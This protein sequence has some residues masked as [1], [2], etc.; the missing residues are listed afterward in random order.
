MK[1]SPVDVDMSDY[2][3]TIIKKLT[4]RMPKGTLHALQLQNNSDK[5]SKHSKPLWE[6]G[7]LYIIIILAKPCH[8]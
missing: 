3:P 7:V 4:N 5:L 2:Q 8:N 1:K 6:L